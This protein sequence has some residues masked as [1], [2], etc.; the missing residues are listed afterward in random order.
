M[1][2]GESPFDRDEFTVR[3]GCHVAVGQHGGKDVRGRLELQAQDVSEP[4][5]AGFEDGPGLKGHQPAQHGIGVLGDAQ[6]TGAVQGMQAR[7]G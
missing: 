6:V 1:D 5:F 3:A 4:V 2:L 7:H